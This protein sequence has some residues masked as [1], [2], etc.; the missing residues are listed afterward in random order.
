MIWIVIVKCY[1]ILFHHLFKSLEKLWSKAA[2]VVLVDGK[3][4]LAASSCQTI[5][6]EIVNT[7]LCKHM[8]C[9]NP[10]VKSVKP[11]WVTT[12]RQTRHSRN[13]LLFIVSNLTLHCCGENNL[14]NKKQ[15]VYIY[16]KTPVFVSS[17]MYY[18]HWN[19]HQILL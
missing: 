3:L 12:D 8:H 6:K 9:V 1:Y 13:Y 2:S 11:L 17:W 5:K 10:N 19:L 15:N 16:N 7:L 18:I 14:R 4:R